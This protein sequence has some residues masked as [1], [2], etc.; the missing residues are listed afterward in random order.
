MT[1]WPAVQA[2]G[3]SVEVVFD[4]L[5]PEHKES[6][7]NPVRDVLLTG[8]PIENTHYVV[9]IA[10]DGSHRHILTSA[11]PIYDAHQAI[12]GVVLVCH[13]VSELFKSRQTLESQEQLFRDV[14]DTTP[15]MLWTMD[16]NRVLTFANRA[17]RDYFGLQSG[18][19]SFDFLSRI[20]E[21]DQN[22]A[23]TMLDRLDAASKG[24]I[25]F[26]HR[27]QDATGRHRWLYT[28][29][30]AVHDKNGVLNSYVGSSLDISERKKAES[31]IEQLA[32]YDS[33]TRLP[34][35]RLMLDRLGRA[36][37]AVK[38]EKLYGAVYYLDLD[39]FKTLNDSMGH[40]VG[41]QLLKQVAERIRSALR[42]E[43][44]VARFGGDEFVI[45]SG[46]L[47]EL[48]RDA[49]RNARLLAEKI[50]YILAQPYYLGEYEYHSTPSIGM[51]LFSYANDSVENVLMQADTAMYRAKS[52]GR[53]NACFYE[54][55]MQETIVH[56]LDMEKGLRQ[57]LRD[58]ALQL[59]YQPQV[60]AEG[61]LIGAEALL[62]WPQPDGRMVSPMSF[63]SVAEDTGLIINIGD[64]VVE[65]ACQQI[66]LWERLQ[67][68][69][70][71]TV[72]VNVS[73]RQFMQSDFVSRFETIV[74]DSG[75]NPGR[76]QIEINE[77]V[78]KNSMDQAIEKMTT[79][80]DR[81]QI[82]ISLDD[83][84]TGFSSLTYLSQFP[85]DEVKIDRA[86][87]R[88]LQTDP[89]D[90][91]L[92]ETILE[93]GH[94]LGVQVIAEGVETQPQLDFLQARRCGRLQGFLFGKPIPAE[95]F[96]GQYLSEAMLGPVS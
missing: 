31:E 4:I 70:D 71:F 94:K 86:F 19:E 15:V 76:L 16:Q 93:I 80:K 61:G 89:K 64:W 56:Q 48:E 63:L 12:Q 20:H 62:R 2:Q 95:D 32:Y 84:G 34:N 17:T 41:D 46:Q 28:M 13:D 14:T 42:A 69:L 1:G 51:T 47:E 92:A 38:R 24:H 22:L 52:E 3:K 83:F 45:L 49:A 88:D 75:V 8:K 58:N 25:Q 81:L 66:I 91:L 85:L 72:S 87:I 96:T 35:R 55:H 54:P 60:N 36:L 67:L 23:A 33:L 53:N 79:L 43:D 74:K 73:P 68:P 10:R 90:A 7:Q 6:L 59:Y 50:R 39:N 40:A 11:A 21:D 37:V 78:V 44:T 5:H 82:K 29:M 57:A 77:N 18:A 26:E 27:M 65:T 9:L 30:K